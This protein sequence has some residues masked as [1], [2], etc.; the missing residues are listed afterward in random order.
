[1][2]SSNSVRGLGDK[3]VPSGAWCVKVYFENKTATTYNHGQK[4]LGHLT[5]CQLVMY[6]FEVG[7][8]NPLPPKQCWNSGSSLDESTSTLCWGWGGGER[9]EGEGEGRWKE[10][11]NVGKSVSRLLDQDCSFSGKKGTHC[12][13]KTDKATHVVNTFK[14]AST[15]NPVSNSVL[16]T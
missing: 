11:P 7:S 5:K 14:T 6:Y 15:Y 3:T 12:S 13:D 9:G 1:M 16:D 8:P 2:K 10:R 4:S